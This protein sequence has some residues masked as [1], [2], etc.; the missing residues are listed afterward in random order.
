MNV[1]T[2]GGSE[3]LGEPV[4]QTA[5]ARP[6]LAEDPVKDR[7]TVD[8]DATERDKDKFN[9]IVSDCTLQGTLA[10]F[11][12]G[13]KEENHEPLKRLSTSPSRFQLRI[14]SRVSPYS[15]TKARYG[16]RDAEADTR[17]QLS[18]TRADIRDLQKCQMSSPGVRA[19]KH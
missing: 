10:E 7:Q 16:R 14:R 8:F 19:L 5:H 12:C 11:W 3:E 17:S 6:C 1:S 2:L 15:P 9:G 13:N 18:S 4:F